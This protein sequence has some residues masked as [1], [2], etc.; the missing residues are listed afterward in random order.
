MRSSPR[1]YASIAEIAQVE[2]HRVSRAIAAVLPDG[3]EIAGNAEKF[4]E[5]ADPREV[6]DAE[7][8]PR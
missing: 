7:M 2:A 1:S 4:A 3:E 8:T 6:R 5:A